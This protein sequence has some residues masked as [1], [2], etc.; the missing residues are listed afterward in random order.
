M[1]DLKSEFPSRKSPANELPKRRQWIIGLLVVFIF[2]ILVGYYLISHGNEFRR[3]W[4]FSYYQT[5]LAGFCLFLG[6]LLNCYQMNLFLRKFGV[7]LSFFELIFVTHGMM[8]GNLVIPMRGGSAGLAIYLKKKYHLNYHKF[9]VIFG[10]TAI[11]VGLVSGV[12]S[13][14]ALFFLKF[15]LQIFEP[16]LTAI[17]IAIIVGCVYLT[18]FP[19]RLKEVGSSKALIFLK[20]LN[21][22]WVSLSRD[23]K[24]LTKVVMS[25]ILITLLQTLAFYVIYIAIGKPLAFVSTLIISSLGAV[26]NLVPITPGS[27]GIFDAVTIQ[28]PRLL[29]LDT[30]AAIMATILIRILSFLICF[31]VGIPGLYYFFDVSRSSSGESPG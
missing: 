24:L 6:F 27:I 1:I 23:R 10:G 16:W 11:L 31:I 13:L 4:E 18:L 28:A 5:I 12:M 30:S 20:R 21:D 25:I 14:A 26:A 19:P 2:F 3:L 22:S 7:R 17:S 9:G 29:G 15:H 8:L